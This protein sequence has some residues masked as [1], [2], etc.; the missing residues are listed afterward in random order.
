MDQDPMYCLLPSEQR[1][2]N[3]L[4]SG[5]H[6]SISLHIAHKYCLELDESQIG[7]CKRWG[8]NSQI[9]HDRVLGHPDRVE[10]LYVAFSVLL[11]AVVKAGEAVTSAV[12]QD[13]PFFEDSLSNWTNFLLPQLINMANDCP[14]T[15]NE[16]DLLINPNIHYKKAEL[17]RRFQHL[18]KIMQCV[19]CDRCKL[20]G[21]LQTIGIGTALKVLFLDDEDASLQLLR[22]EAVALVHTLERLSS[23]LV[24]AYD[25]RK[26]INFTSK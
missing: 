21:T 22:Q 11:R 6:S 2:Y 14:N 1:L 18:Q 15:F 8:I 7:E 4:I 5:L 17:Q 24:Y 12:P 19:G 20:W 10:N 23:S 3:R 16:Y 26:R 13:D 25:M 9:A